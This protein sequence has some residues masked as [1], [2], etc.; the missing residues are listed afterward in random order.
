MPL[1]WGW[2]KPD[3]RENSVREGGWFPR[4]ANKNPRVKKVG[5]FRMKEK[6][7]TLSLVG[8]KGGSVEGKEGRKEKR[9]KGESGLSKKFL[10]GVFNARQPC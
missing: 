7:E 9:K 4:L 6:G 5:L 1:S 2:Q 8:G 10:V 3:S